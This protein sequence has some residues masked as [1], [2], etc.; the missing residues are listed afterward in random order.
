M[1]PTIPFFEGKLVSMVDV[2]GHPTWYPKI[3][4]RRFPTH[5]LGKKTSR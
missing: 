4:H 5:H 3:L 1:I 2:C